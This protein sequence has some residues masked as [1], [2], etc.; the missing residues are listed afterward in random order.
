M[1]EKCEFKELKLEDLLLD[2]ENPRFAS[3]P[4]SDDL[5]IEEEQQ[6]IIGY[7]L[8]HENVISLAKE[9]N[10]RGIL[11][12][13]ELIACYPQG[14]KY[15]VAE[16]NRRTCACK[17][18]LNRK[19]I[20]KKYIDEFPFL[21]K[22]IKQNLEIL[23][24][25]IYPDRTSTLAF[26]SD[27]HISGP[28]K[29]SAREKNKYYFDLF[30]RYK[31][32][33]SIMK[34]TREPIET[35]KD[36]I[37]R[38]QFF[39]DVFRTLSDEKKKGY[40][41]EELDYRP[42]VDLFMLT[43]VGDDPE[44]GLNLSFDAELLKYSCPTEKKEQYNKI[45]ALIGEAFL[46]RGKARKGIDRT[47]NAICKI[48]SNEVR[49][50][51]QRKQLIKDNI[52]IPGLLPLIQEYNDHAKTLTG[53]MGENIQPPAPT[54][55]PLNGEPPHP[56]PFNLKKGTNSTLAFAEE[57]LKSFK[58]SGTTDM[59]EKIRW[60]LTELKN[61]S[62]LTSPYTCV[63]L[64]R[65]LLEASTKFYYV[66]HRESIKEADRYDVEEEDLR[67]LPMAMKKLVD[68]YLFIGA[69]GQNAKLRKDIQNC[70]KD[71]II[72]TLNLAIHHFKKIEYMRILSSWNTMKY[73]IIA[74]LNK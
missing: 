13:P 16:G 46:L 37:T 40:E 73:F 48:V 15:I 27:R 38:Y 69:K 57:E 36:A 50:K 10:A 14:E 20:P 2:K 66:K 34:H 52:R 51:T 49:N 32:L 4:L 43:I 61:K 44:V 23:R 72:N 26:L 30:K 45:L 12:G 71:E 74:C 8:D 68:N 67:S 58:I 62:I 33:D 29:W 47:Q 18:L 70:L 59:E 39:Q 53:N 6:A 60:L 24:A 65:T 41:L 7:L 11:H 55:E 17:L 25:C 21:N 19:L 1:A 64:Y 42:M 22:E 28:K 9:I 5:S 35:V 3:T 54:P 31:N 63:L 56:K